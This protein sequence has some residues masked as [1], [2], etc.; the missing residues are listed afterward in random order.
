M[1]TDTGL[2]TRSAFGWNLNPSYSSSSFANAPSGVS[3]CASA[4]AAMCSGKFASV[5]SRV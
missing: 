5:S 1:P 3:P 2:N 4:S